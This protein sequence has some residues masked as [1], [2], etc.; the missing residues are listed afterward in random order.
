M[1]DQHTVIWAKRLDALPQNRKQKVLEYLR[2]EEERARPNHESEADNRL[3][4]YKAKLEKVH[5]LKERIDFIATDI[6]TILHTALSKNQRALLAEYELLTFFIFLCNYKASCLFNE[7]GSEF[8]AAIESI[9]RAHRLL[10]RLKKAEKEK[11]GG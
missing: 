4:E 8:R 5:D 7:T 9:A 2:F 11:A 1:T 10:V 6:N 3:Q